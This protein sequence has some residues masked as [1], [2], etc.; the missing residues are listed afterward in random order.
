MISVFAV[1]LVSV[2]CGGDAPSSVANTPSDGGPGQFDPI[3]TNGV[4]SK[5]KVSTANTEKCVS[6][7]SSFYSLTGNGTCAVIMVSTLAGTTGTSGFM[8][9]AGNVAQFNKPYR[10]AVDSSGN[11][12]VA[13]TDNH[14]IR[15]IIIPQ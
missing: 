6:C 15:K 13:D 5:T 4:A 10:V 14:R 2:Q 7:S 8:D 9:G 1:L 11:I 12:Y 3:C